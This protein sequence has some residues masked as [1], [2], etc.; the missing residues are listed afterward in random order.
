GHSVAQIGYRENIM[1]DVTA[2]RVG[3]ARLVEQLASDL[4]R[5]ATHLN[6]HEFK[7]LRLLAAFD[8]RKGWESAGARSCVEWITDKVGMGRRGARERLRVARALTHLPLI[9]RAMADGALS[10]SKVR[11][12]VRIATAENESGL[13]EL[14]RQNTAA[15]VES[16]VR[17]APYSGVVPA[18]DH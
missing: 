12:V 3:D 2:P 16:A 9:S 11:A 7:W 10:F 1:T 15:Q 4:I 18:T 13:L 6:A 5:L 17:T 8:A 14:A